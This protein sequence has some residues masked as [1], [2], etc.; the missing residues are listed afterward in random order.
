MAVVTIAI[1]N[2]GKHDPLLGHDGRCSTRSRFPHPLLLVVI[3]M[4]NPSLTFN[5]PALAWSRYEDI[6]MTCVFVRVHRG[7]AF[8]NFTLTGNGEPDQLNSQ[9]I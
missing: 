1:G 5:A 4:N 6:R 8:D 9:R 3:W 7:L 2:R